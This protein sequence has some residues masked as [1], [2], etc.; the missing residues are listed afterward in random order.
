MNK[1]CC[2]FVNHKPDLYEDVFERMSK[3]VDYIDFY[4]INPDWNAIK[5]LFGLMMFKEDIHDK[6]EEHCGNEIFILLYYKILNANYDYYFFCENDVLFTGDYKLLFDEL[7]KKIYDY[8]AI[9]QNELWYPPKDWIWLSND[10]YYNL[11][12]GFSK[13]RCHNLL[14]KFYCFSNELVDYILNGYIDGYYGHQDLCV[15]CMLKTFKGKYDYLS[16]HFL[17]KIM[18]SEDDISVEDLQEENSIIHPVKQ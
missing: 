18:P 17:T 8:D 12:D 13:N 2:I 15:S 5:R 10:K 1:I 16:N 9:I 11:L 3:S 4:N 6:I 7:T 14:Y